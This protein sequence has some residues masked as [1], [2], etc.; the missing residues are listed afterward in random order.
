MKTYIDFYSMYI[1]YT[2]TDTQL[3]YKR[4]KKRNV[5]GVT[6]SPVCIDIYIYNIISSVV[7]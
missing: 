3:L 1:Q 2:H 4:I 6:H 7:V 5:L